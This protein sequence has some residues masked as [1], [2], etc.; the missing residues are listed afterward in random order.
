MQAF[1]STVNSYIV[2]PA[3][4]VLLAMLLGA[5]PG[6]ALRG[7]LHICVALV[8]VGMLFSFFLGKA[9][10]ILLALMRITGKQAGITDVGWPQLSMLVWTLQASYLIIPIAFGV[11]LGMVALGWTRTVNVDI[12]NFWHIAVAGFLVYAQTESLPLAAAADA[13]MTVVT[14]KLA[15]WIKPALEQTYALDG[16]MTIST[17][18]SLT[19]LPLA[20]LVNRLLDLLPSVGRPGRPTGRGGSG[21]AFLDTGVLSLLVGFVVALIARR[22]L[23]EAVDFSASTAA[24]FLLLPGVVSFMKSGFRP[25]TDAT[26]RFVK[27]LFRGR[28]EI[29]VGVNHMILS[30]NPSVVVSAI[31]LMPIAIAMSLLLPW[32]EIFP[33]A[34]L[35]NI[36]CLIVTIVAVCRGDVVRSVL[37]GIPAL[38]LCLVCSSYVA[39]LYTRMGAVLGVPSAVPGLWAASVNGNNYLSVWVAELL[40]GRPW[41]LASLPVALLAGYAC[42]RYC[43]AA[44][45]RAAH[46]ADSSTE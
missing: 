32:V 39:P 45:Q 43:A 16:N 25:V 15:D 44:R 21:R 37:T 42:R 46:V 19:Y 26:E 11:N 38:L 18:N 2:L 1:L 14:L 12:W 4:M 20:L 33:M 34:D 13:L 24:V 29:V 27:R 36:V 40:M 17:M 6:E 28:R 35:T 41:A 22:P 3:L 23:H 5:R 30:D 31:L 8:G 10:P 7:G 9:Q